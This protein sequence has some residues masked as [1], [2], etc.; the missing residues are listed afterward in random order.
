[1]GEGLGTVRY[2]R[3][4]TRQGETT[5]QT[6]SDE[7]HEPD[8]HKARDTDIS[9]KYRL[10]H[11]ADVHKGAK[12]S[13]MLQTQMAGAPKADGSPQPARE[14][15]I[16]QAYH[17]YSLPPVCPWEGRKEGRRRNKEGGGRKE[18]WKGV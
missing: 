11:V 18:A 12:G 6:D 9:P 7:H 1:M 4:Q 8:L 10:R 13:H 16:L 2:V 3:E 5:N 17:S 15:H 14:T